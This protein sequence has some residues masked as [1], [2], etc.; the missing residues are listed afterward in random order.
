[1][2]KFLVTAK[3]LRAAIQAPLPDSHKGQNGRVLLIVGG[4]PLFH[5]AGRFSS[6]AA[7]E[8]LAGMRTAVTFASRTNDMVYFCSTPQ[9]I[10]LIK[11]ESDAFIGI[12]REQLESY[13]PDSDAVLVGPGLMRTTEV[14]FPETEKEPFITKQLTKLVLN[15]G[16]KAVLDAGSLQI[17]SPEILK[18]KK[19]VIITPHRG[20]LKMLFGLEPSETLISHRSSFGEI[21]K[22]AEKIS[23][24]AGRY[25]ITIVLKGPSDIIAGPEGWYYSP[26]GNA[27]MTKGGTGDVLAGVIT[28]IYSGTDNPLMAAAAGSFL[29]KRAGEAIAKKK[30]WFFNATDLAEEISSTLISQLRLHR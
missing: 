26:G 2:D 16:K 20:E 3:I 15:S 25:G 5:G 24:I 12:T 30:L 29:V 22:V 21:K 4:S 10:N 23:L 7:G 14:N 18:G 28:A 9:N 19:Q 13:L 17:L 11:K 27:G 6:K 1:M 8:V